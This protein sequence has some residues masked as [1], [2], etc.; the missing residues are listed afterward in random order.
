MTSKHIFG[1]LVVIVALI[2]LKHI[3]D[4]SFSDMVYRGPLPYDPFEMFVEFEE[5][6]GPQVTVFLQQNLSG[7]SK[8]FKSSQYDLRKI[9]IDKDILNDNIR[10]LK[11][12]PYTKVT[13]FEHMNYKGNHVTYENKQDIIMDI[14]K[15]DNQLL[16]K[17]AS[18]I[19]IELVQPYAI[20]Y[21]GDNLGGLSKVYSGNVPVLSE[22]FSK[23]IVSLKLSPY[24]KLTFFAGRGDKKETQQDPE[25]KVF[26]N[27]TQHDKH[28]NFVGAEWNKKIASLK[29]EKLFV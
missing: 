2:L 5:E 25:P 27:N 24:T 21:T 28:I 6:A 1:L 11:I 12:G 20:T 15:I 23:K 8:T 17:K 3:A 14:T 9:A 10:S 16:D 7:P 22:P 19:K 13:L 18:S 29:I 4:W 26:T